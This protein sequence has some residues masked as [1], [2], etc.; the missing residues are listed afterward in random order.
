MAT[1]PPR[2]CCCLSG[3]LTPTLAC[4]GIQHFSFRFIGT[5]NDFFRSMPPISTLPQLP[6]IF[7]LILFFATISVSSSLHRWFLQITIYS[8]WVKNFI[9]LLEMIFSFWIQT[10]FLIFLEMHTSYVARYTSV[11]PTYTPFRSFE[12]MHTYLS[13]TR[14]LPSIQILLKLTLGIYLWRLWFSLF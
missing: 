4:V 3:S 6:P 9:N 8:G 7:P 14:V 13:S 5:L 12:L 10:A 2:D 1:Q 11:P